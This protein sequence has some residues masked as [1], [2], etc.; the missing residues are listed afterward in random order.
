MLRRVLA[1]TT[2]FRLP[3]EGM[4]SYEVLSR[5]SAILGQ[6]LAN[7]DPSRLHVV[8]CAHV[9]CPWL[10]PA[11]YPNDWLQHVDEAYVKHTLSLHDAESCTKTWEIDLESHV[12]LHPT[13]DLAAL[14]LNLIT[15]NVPD[16]AGYD[17][18][19]LVALDES[20]QLEYHGHIEPTPDVV[21]PQTVAGAYFWANPSTRQVFGKSDTVLAQGMCGGAVT[22]HDT[23]V[24]LIEGIVPEKANA[25]PAYKTLENAVAFVPQ[26]DIVAFLH[27]KELFP[28]DAHTLF[29]NTLAS[30]QA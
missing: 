28:A 7:L 30:I 1:L 29:T 23:V 4:A 27:V 20:T 14:E 12:S 6:R 11:Y 21:Q 3:H 22:A 16:L 19:V 2:Q 26:D 25:T 5:G 13:R 10:F 15:A 18:S 24:G 8:T 9:A 17:L